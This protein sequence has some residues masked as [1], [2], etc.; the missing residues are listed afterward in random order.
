M[1]T[2]ELDARFRAAALAEG[3]VDVRFDV[4]ESPVGDLFIAATPRG[5]CRI[6]YPVE[7]QDEELARMFG[8]RVLRMP[9]D[10]VRRELDEYFEGRRHDFD[11]PLD[12]RVAPFHEAVLHELARVPYGQHRHLRRPGSEGRPAEGGAGGRHGDEPQPDPDRAPLPP[13][14]RRE[15]LAH[16]LRRRAGREARAA[17]ARGRDPSFVNFPEVESWVRTNLPPSPARVLEIGA[18]EGE[19][20]RALRGT[21]YDVTAI[22]PKSE[23]LDVQPVELADLPDPE[24]PFEAAVAVVSL[25]HIEPLEAS[26][27]RLAAVLEPGAPL[28]VDEFDASALDERA[29]A[30]WLE[31][32]HARGGEDPE[33]PEEL[34]PKMREKVHSIEQLVSVLSRWFDVGELVP[35][36]YLYRWHLDESVRPAE[37]ELV[38][39]GELPLTGV[40]FIARL[41]R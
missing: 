27:E 24:R 17:R 30:W 41:K 1:L 6:S 11:L 31:Q 39:R 18:G 9:L 32:R 21:G 8:V 28:I 37:E 25:H 19:L 26:V 3:L 2:P 22:D 10:E 23:R 35:G 34:G 12:L 15:R 38:A 29:A 33:T 7:G 36:T 14:R 16:R 4:T 40:R 13:D 20:A 5:L